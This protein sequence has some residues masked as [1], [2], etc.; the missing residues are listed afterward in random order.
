MNKLI[1]SAILSSSLLIGATTIV[2]SN[3]SNLKI[4]IYNNNLAFVNENRE[5]YVN[6][7]FQKI[8]YEGVPSKVITESVIPNFKGTNLNLFSQ[9]Y[10]YDLISQGSM[11]KNSINNNIEYYSNHS[12]EENNPKLLKGVLL[13]VNPVMIKTEEDKKIITLNSANQVIFGSVPKNMITKP[14]L[15]WNVELE[16]SSNLGIDLKYL[17]R[18]ISWKS[19]Y[20]LNLEKNTLNLNGWIT[21][22]NNSGVSYNDATITCLAGEINRAPVPQRRKYTKNMVLSEGF[23]GDKKVKSESFSGYHIYKIPFEE[24][25]LNKQKKQINFIDKK[26]ISFFQYGKSINNNFENYG[27]QKLTFK[28]IVEFKNSKEN[29]MGIPLPSGIVRMYKKDS[30]GKSH[31]IGEDRVSN[32]P[33]DETVKLKI[34][35]LFDVV[36]EKTITKFR[37]DRYLREV[38]TTYELRNRGSE[39]VILKIEEKIPTYGREISVGTSCMKQCSFEKKS[40]FYREFTIKLKPEEVYSFRTSFEVNFH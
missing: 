35:N 25:I 10:M 2:P 39:S 20:V 5:V 26:S 21:I 24:S 6:K 40:A 15:I 33:K 9:N 11:L 8:V 32:I 31:F 29:N 1:L 3:N 13:S 18:G 7:G 36:G 16:K 14:S 38:E 17:T 19:D 4:T 28:N 37:A 12:S 22:N 34:G 23:G 27:K 30:K